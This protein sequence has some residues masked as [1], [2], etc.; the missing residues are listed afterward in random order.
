MSAERC[1]ALASPLATALGA[2][3]LAA[4]VL[5]SLLLAA[6]HAAQPR[7]AAPCPGAALSALGTAGL[8][9]VPLS[10][11]LLAREQRPLRGNA[12]AA[13]LAPALTLLGCG[14]L[15]SALRAATGGE[16]PLRA[17]L[18]ALLAAAARAPRAPP[19]ALLRGSPPAQQALLAHWA[20]N[21]R[22]LLAYPVARAALQARADGARAAG[23]AA[24]LLDGAAPDFVEQA[25]ALACRHVPGW[26]ATPPAAI[27]AAVVSGGITNSLT[28]LARA[29]AHG[30]GSVLVRLF[31]AGSDALIDRAR[32]NALFARMAARG[33]G[34]PLHCVFGNG[35]LEGWVEHSRPLEPREMSA[36]EPLDLAAHLAR[37]LACQ[38]ALADVEPSPAPWQPVLWARLR[39]WVAA[40][41]AATVGASG[42]RYVSELDWLEEA[43]PSPRNGGGA[44]LLAAMAGEGG[45]GG[46]LQAARCQAAALCFSVVFCHNDVLSG[47]VLLVQPP[48]QPARV[49]LIDFEYMAPNYLAYDLA[50]CFM[51]HCGFLPFEPEKDYP[52]PAQQRHFL[53]EY[54]AQHLAS[55]GGSAQPLPPPGECREAFME[56]MRRWINLFGFASHLW[57][58]CGGRGGR[59]QLALSSPSSSHSHA[60]TYTPTHARALSRPGRGPVGPHPGHAQHRRLSLCCLL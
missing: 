28:R 43:L 23:D 8:A 50:N 18:P 46:A 3:L 52:S 11:V 29:S 6:R 40:V 49:Q 33:Y 53:D 10:A 12:L 9:L 32:D 45:G 47:N 20:A 38:H 2:G 16:A 13:Q 37:A 60:H 55:A 31:G 4:S 14:G 7:H 57:C 27:A 15:V 54:L 35:R 5:A 58:A 19:R 26:A 21:A 51:E 30:G 17:Y 59:A 39:E 34:P 36:R 41:A 25:R 48:A 42:A 56:E 1:P 22:A 44:A 24:R